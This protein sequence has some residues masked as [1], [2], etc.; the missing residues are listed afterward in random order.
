VPVDRDPSAGAP[1]AGS[2]RVRETGSADAP[3]AHRVIASRELMGD[4]R[5]LIIRH[6]DGEYRLRLTLAGKLILTK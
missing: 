3:P 5:V 1:H 4:D 6:G 2:G